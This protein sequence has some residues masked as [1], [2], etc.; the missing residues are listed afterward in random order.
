M[1]RQSTSLEWNCVGQGELSMSSDDKSIVILLGVL[2]LVMAILYGV[3]T[4]F[5]W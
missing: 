2:A 1:A 5:Q 4:A 3:S